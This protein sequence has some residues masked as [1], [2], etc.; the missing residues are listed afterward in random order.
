MIKS[1]LLVIAAL[2]VVLLIYASTRPDSFRVERSARIQAPPERLH[3]LINDMHAFNTWNPYA[4]KDPS[5]KGSY[6]GPP[7]GTGAAYAWESDK[8]GTGR[9]EIVESA[10]PDTVAMKLDFIKPF[11]AH[12]TAAFTIQP[13]ADATRVTWSMQG[14]VPYVGKIMHLFFDMDRIVGKDFEEGLV[15]LK[16]LAEAG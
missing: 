8:V 3:A 5:M 10:A 13:E 12:N 1:T 7:Q 15:N 16:A 11:E 9:L 4:R 6:A 14:P 2:I